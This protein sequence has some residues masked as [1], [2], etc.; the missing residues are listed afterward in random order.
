VAGARTAHDADDRI[1]YDTSS[2]KL[3]YDADG[4]GTVQS[5]QVAVLANAPALAATDIWVG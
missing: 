4:T 1:V 2:G 5:V 3:Y